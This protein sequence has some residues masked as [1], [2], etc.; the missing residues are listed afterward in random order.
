MFDQIMFFGPRVPPKIDLT[1][2]Q[3]KPTNGSPSRFPKVFLRDEMKTSRTLV[4][5]L[6]AL[7]LGVLAWAHWPIESLPSGTTADRILVEKAVR[8][9]TLYRGATALRSYPVSLGVVPVGPK[10]REGDKKTPEGLF[11][12]TEHKRD[13]SFH[14]ALRVS[15]PEPADVERARK[16][17]VPPG[18][19][20]MV[21]GLP[22]GLGLLGRLHRLNLNS[23]VG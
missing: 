18:S 13:S 9:L 10:E 17:N 22:N 16:M 11:R 20:I 12:I 21:H 19:D 6:L 5:A 2:E 3:R 15:Y 4:L 1:D 8:R 23:A 14:L 7:P